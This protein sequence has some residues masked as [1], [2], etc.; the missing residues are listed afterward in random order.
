MFRFLQF[1]LQGVE[2]Y[3]ETLR[4]PTRKRRAV[5]IVAD[6][7]CSCYVHAALNMQRLLHNT[8]HSGE[9]CLGQA[10]AYSPSAPAK[11]SKW[12]V[13][14]YAASRRSTANM[15]GPGGEISAGERTGITP[16][17]ATNG[18]RPNRLNYVINLCICEKPCRLEA[19]L[20]TARTYSQ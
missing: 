18:L 3:I 10:H 17:E 7:P 11:A 5:A 9:D 6:L 15:P 4:G 12:R 1:M 19:S 2:V 14:P 20:L 16:P 8:T 13:E